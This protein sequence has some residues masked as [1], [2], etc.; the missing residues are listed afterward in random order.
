MGNVSLR[1]GI[2]NYGPRWGRFS[3]IG[4]IWYN[5]IMMAKRDQITEIVHIRGFGIPQQVPIEFSQD[6]APEDDLLKN[7]DLD[8][9]LVKFQNRG[10]PALLIPIFLNWND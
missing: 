2:C 6:I 1:T 5:S 4:V 8:V 7:S 9:F 10:I 3:V